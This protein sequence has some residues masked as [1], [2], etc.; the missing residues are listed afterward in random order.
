V[1]STLLIS[2]GFLIISANADNPPNA[3]NVVAAV[4]LGGWA[5]V[6]VVGA[7]QRALVEQEDPQ[8]VRQAGLRLGA[9]AALTALAIS[10]GLPNPGPNDKGLAIATAVIAA[11]GFA[12]LSVVLGAARRRTLISTRQYTS[13]IAGLGIL[14]ASEVGRAIAA[15]FVIGSNSL[16]S[17]RIGESV[18][19]IVYA[20]GFLVL[21]WAALGRIAE[22]ATGRPEAPG[23]APTSAEPSVVA[24]PSWQPDPS[25]R[26]QIR[27]WDGTRW[28]EHVSD[29]NRPAVDPI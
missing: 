14:A 8:V 17:L 3:A 15:G 11:V 26:H 7:A 4:G 25:G 27:W 1:V 23:V 24:P 28:T 9:A 13:V 5:V 6:L 20:L 12:G 21:G 29:D 16:L 10:L 18:P 2:I 22:L 19:I